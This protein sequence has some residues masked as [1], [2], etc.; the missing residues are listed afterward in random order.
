M[1]TEADYRLP[2]TVVP[3]HYDLEIAPDL[4]TSRF[5]GTVAIDVTVVEPTETVVLNAVDLDIDEA[6]VVVGEVVH[7]ATVRMDAAHERLVLSVA[8][9]L[10]AGPAM[11]RIR[12]TGV[13]SDQLR[14]FY[15]S[16]Y[17]DDDGNDHVLATTQFESTDAR[18][19]FPCW[20][21]PD[22]KATFDV[23]LTVDEAIEAVSNAREVA[24]R[25]LGD[26]TKRI[27]FARTAVMST[28]L[29]A[30]V[31]GELVATDPVD[32]K[33]VPLRIVTPPG[34][35]H[36]ADFALEAGAFA[37]AYFADY[38]DVPYPGDKLDM[39]AVPDFG[40]GAMENLGCIIYRES[41]LLLDP[42]SATRVELARVA[43]VIAHEIAHM[44][45]GDLVTMKWWN[46]VWLNEAFATF[47]EVKCTDAFRPE[48]NYWLDFANDRAASQE[49]DALA[50]TRPIEFP[51][52]S[53][54]DAD[55]MF[56]VLTY[57]KGAAVLRMLEV[58]LTEDVFRRGISLYLQRHSF[59]NTDTPDLWRALEDVSG[60]PV[61]EIMDTWIF[62]GGYPIVDAHTVGG[63][64]SLHQR[65]FRLLGEG[66][67]SWQIPVRYRAGA[68]VHRF[69]LGDE[70]VVLPADDTVVVNAGGEGFFRVQYAPDL[71]A[72]VTSAMPDLDPVE[73]YAVVSD[74]LAGMLAGDVDAADYLALVATLVDEPEID[75][76]KVALAGVTEL[77]RVVSSDDRDALRAF[78][79]TLVAP[80]ADDLG[81]VPADG[82]DDATGAL[83]NLILRTLGTLGD[84][85]GTIRLAREVDGA[86]GEVDAEVADASLWI[87]A[88]HGD[89]DDHQRFLAL[90]EAAETPQRKVKYL[91]AAA[92]VPHPEVPAAMFERI[93]DGRVRSQDSFWLL[94][95]MLGHR[96]NGP[97]T[98]N[99][100]MDHW[101][102][103]ME[104]MAPAHRYRMLDFIKYRSEP[105]VASSIEAWFDDHT[106]DGAEKAISQRL[107]MIRVRVG[108]RERENPRLGDAIA[109]AGRGWNP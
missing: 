78:V 60:E 65:P 54:A 71:F 6:V 21:E 79:R 41:A 28:Y 61:G 12:Y 9:P 68:S 96:E 37:L 92:S 102:A 56:D 89:L 40:F 1:A 4:A 50:A 59:A 3:S 34:Q 46:G 30:F 88:A 17:T 100:V 74:A 64:V 19:A 105:E 81:W 31:V 25:S 99:L 103:V 73:R 104:V 91:R 52:V 107:E 53:P 85:P 8:E 58:Y 95:V 67:G 38:Y 82:E 106:I 57:E 98:W 83:R 63:G 84:D 7:R 39:V 16:T 10:P 2:R 33:G 36:L 86:G 77:D 44:W 15:R 43:S 47:A 109:A 18:R 32:V 55:A 70:A 76:W 72:E 48:W 27:E 75:V 45:F 90:S 5:V 51:V 24:R 62:Q 94:A 13:L 69:V 108:L 26:G 80:R 66:E 23:A 14:G 20:D 101:D 22:L 29:V 93:L 35:L 49:T 97:A 11:V 42:T 87:V